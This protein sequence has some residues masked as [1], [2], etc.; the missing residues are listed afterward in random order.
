[1]TVKIMPDH[2]VS[3][4][5]EPTNFKKLKKTVISVF[6]NNEDIRNYALARLKKVQEEECKLIENIELYIKGN[7]FLKGGIIYR[8]RYISMNILN[9]GTFPSSGNNIA[10]K[11]LSDLFKVIKEKYHKI[12]TKLTQTEAEK[13]DRADNFLSKYHEKSTE[14]F[15]LEQKDLHASQAFKS[16]L[17][18]LKKFFKKSVNE[19]IYFMYAWPTDEKRSKEKWIQPFLES[20]Q[21][22]L[23]KAGFPDVRFDIVSNRM[24]ADINKFMEKTES[25]SYVLL[26]ASESLRIKHS[27]GTSAVCTEFN[28]VQ[29][30]R[31]KDYKEGLTRIFPIILSGSHETSLP[32][33]FKRFITVRDW[34][35]GGYLK[36]FQTLFIELLGLPPE[37]YRKQLNNLWENSA[38]KYPSDCGNLNFY[39]QK[40]E[41]LEE[42][43]VPK[44]VNRLMNISFQNSDDDTPKSVQ[45]LIKAKKDREKI[46]KFAKGEVFPLIKEMYKTNAMLSIFTFSKKG[47]WELKV[48]VDNLYVKIAMIDDQEKK[49]REA[50][51]RKTL[52]EY[53]DPRPTDHG[54]IFKKELDPA[55]IFSEELLEKGERPVVFGSAG[56]GKTTFVNHMLSLWSKGE[57]WTKFKI[58][59]CLPLRNLNKHF[60][61]K[62][63]GHVYKASELLQREYPN[64]GIDFQ[65]LLND[66]EFLKESLLIL[67]GYDGLPSEA[68]SK[69]RH[70]FKAFED[71]KKLFPNIL[72]T[73]RSAN[74]IEFNSTQEFEI[75]GF[76][77][78]QIETYISK[79][80]D[81]IGVEKAD[82]QQ[83]IESLKSY[84]SKTPLADSLAHIPINLSI[85][86]ALFNEDKTLFQKDKTL[87]TTKLY[88]YITN[89][90]YKVFLLRSGIGKDEVRSQKS[91]Q[92]HYLVAPLNKVLQ[93]IAI[94]AMEQDSLY[95]DQVKI[96]E[97]VYRNNLRIEQVKSIGLFR[98]EGGKGSFI[99]YTFQE[100]LTATFIAQLYIDGKQGKA[101]V[102]IKTHKF[103]PRYSLVLSM[104]AGYL[105]SQK[106][107]KSLQAF[108]D[109]LFSPPRDL[110]KSYELSL[111]AQCF[112]EC[113]FPEEIT[114]YKKEF[115][116]N[117]IH[118]IEEAPEKKIIIRLL[119][120]TNLLKNNEVLEKVRKVSEWKN[121]NHA[122][123]KLLAYSIKD[124][125]SEFLPILGQ[126]LSDLESY[127]IFRK[128]S[129]PIQK[130][131][132]EKLKNLADKNK[133]ETFL[134]RL[135]YHMDMRSSTLGFYREVKDPGINA[136]MFLMH[137]ARKGNKT[138][139]EFLVKSAWDYLDSKKKLDHKLGKDKINVLKEIV[140]LNRVDCKVFFK[141]LAG[142]ITSTSCLAQSSEKD[143]AEQQLPCWKLIDV[144]LDL[145]FQPELINYDFYLN[146]LIEVAKNKD[147]WISKR[148][149]DFLESIA[150]NRKTSAGKV[151]VVLENLIRDKSFLHVKK[152][153][154]LSLSNIMILQKEANMDSVALL[155]TAGE[156]FPNLKNEVVVRLSEI[157]AKISRIEKKI[158]D[159]LIT[160][161]TLNKQMHPLDREKITCNLLRR[162]IDKNQ[163]KTKIINTL[164]GIAFRYQISPYSSGV[165]AFCIEKLA[166]AGLIS[167][168]KQAALP[169]I[170]FISDTQ[171]I[172][173]Q[174]N[175][176]TGSS[177][178]SSQLK[179]V[180][181][182]FKLIKFGY[183]LPQKNLEEMLFSKSID[184]VVY[185]D[186]VCG[187]IEILEKKKDFFQKLELAII[188][189][190]KKPSD[191]YQMT[192]CIE[193]MAR[194]GY[195]KCS[196]N[197]KSL[198]NFLIKNKE[199][200]GIDPKIRLS[201]ALG[202]IAK[203]ESE[204]KAHATGVMLE[205]LK[206]KN[207]SIADYRR[208]NHL[209]K[210]LIDVD[211]TLPQQD[212]IRTWVSI[213]VFPYNAE[214]LFGASMLHYEAGAWTNK[215]VLKQVIAG[216]VEEAQKPE[217]QKDAVWFLS[218]MAK[219]DQDS[220]EQVRKS[221][222]EVALYNIEN[223]IDF[224]AFESLE[225]SWFTN[226]EEILQN[227]FEKAFSSKDKHFLLKKISQNSEEK[228]INCK[229][230]LSS[231]LSNEKN[232]CEISV[233]LDAG[234]ML[235]KHSPYNQESILEKLLEITNKQGTN[236]LLSIIR[237][238]IFYTSNLKNQANF[239][240]KNILPLL[241]QIIQCNKNQEIALLCRT[242]DSASSAL[243]L[244]SESED[245]ISIFLHLLLE[246][247]NKNAGKEVTSA[248]IRLAH[249]SKDSGQKII[250][251]V[252][253]RLIELKSMDYSNVLRF[254]SFI[255]NKLEQ[256]E[257]VSKENL[258]ILVSLMNPKYSFGRA[259]QGIL[260]VLQKVKVE[261]LKN[262]IQDDGSFVLVQ[263]ICYLTGKP[264]VYD[265]YKVNQSLLKP[266]NPEQA[267][268]EVSWPSSYIPL[269]HDNG[270]QTQGMKNSKGRVMASSSPIKKQ[271]ILIRKK[272]HIS[273]NRTFKPYLRTK[274]IKVPF[275]SDSDDKLFNSPSQ[276]GGLMEDDLR[277]GT[278]R[279]RSLG[280]NELKYSN[281]R[282]KTMTEDNPHLEGKTS[283]ELQ[284]TANSS[285]RTRNIGSMID[286]T[287]VD[288]FD[289]T[290]TT[291]LYPSRQKLSFPLSFFLSQE[292]TSLS[293]GKRGSKPDDFLHI[294]F[295]THAGL[296][297]YGSVCYANASLQALTSKRFINQ[298]ELIQQNYKNLSS[299]S[300]AYLQTLREIF[301]KS[302]SQRQF[303]EFLVSE[304]GNMST[305]LEN[306]ESDQETKKEAAAQTINNILTRFEGA[307]SGKNSLKSRAQGFLRKIDQGNCTEN[308]YLA[309]TVK[310]R[311]LCLKVMQSL[312]NDGKTI[313]AKELYN[314][315]GFGAPFQDIGEFTTRFLDQI[316]FGKII[317]H[318]VLSISQSHKTK[319]ISK[320][321]DSIL[322]LPLHNGSIQ[323][324]LDK[325]FSTEE[326]EILTEEG[327]THSKVVL[328]RAPDILPLTLKRFTDHARTIKVTID[329]EIYVMLSNGKKFWYTLQSMGCYQPGHYV[330]G[331]RYET[332][333]GTVQWIE[334]NDAS[335]PKVIG[336]QIQ[337]W[338][339]EP[340]KNACLL[341]YHKKN[342]T[343]IAKLATSKPSVSNSSSIL[344]NASP[345]KTHSNLSSVHDFTSE[346]TAIENKQKPTSV[347]EL[348]KLENAIKAS[349][350]SD[351]QKDSLIARI[352]KIQSGM[353]SSSSSNK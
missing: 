31:E 104:I 5:L 268:K 317:F 142:K 94:Y 67:E 190:L 23:K 58:V 90:F 144:L 313:S 47:E 159:F 122:L 247:F 71:L 133:F 263:K 333:D 136:F 284:P 101:K 237:T 54:T 303:H 240:K 66:S 261:Y 146:T 279:S 168:F 225:A 115:I 226:I 118:Y 68:K 79:F 264:L 321:R 289:P 283:K 2:E 227:I 224:S 56:I 163:D 81:E 87:T 294:S 86:C 193:K 323:E 346:L 108:F 120:R 214:K 301:E 314:A 28:H 14:L 124:I 9:K 187:F 339:R 75:V 342:E 134:G 46:Y 175:K 232:T 266:I 20:L 234:I 33:G 192:F 336:P 82:K 32:T 165:A 139:Q 105:A 292:G 98:V 291:Q 309:D 73:S 252:F 117:V 290:T 285:G 258:E 160:A 48:P 21:K 191:T 111:F 181:A 337:S 166:S 107:Q 206:I 116:P 287:Q 16:Y 44:D 137:F 34:R 135:A 149:I 204:L 151:K 257:E 233:R 251:L 345:L 25:S 276:G 351:R 180:E 273:L 331:C 22:A 305:A 37:K 4:R 91:P 207:L 156:Q 293:T 78:S 316:G 329:E 243:R 212:T 152:Q 205:L 167:D 43:V 97:I 259:Y 203:G 308:A 320:E 202:E 265:G 45:R 88:S 211:C 275:I 158:T 18:A 154:I 334:H 325:F 140:N 244:I 221:F 3:F 241:I 177:K 280:T 330:T 306:L 42:C 326:L 173:Y 69:G 302:G 269:T 281:K 295:N 246:M 271:K 59:F 249:I 89:H 198:L 27:R 297:N 1:M 84:L 344:N 255:D 349:N 223:K 10:L 95:V 141:K 99:H 40:R 322:Q 8:I 310:N 286:Q 176:L 157:A 145:F 153:S 74:T 195:F 350:L 19:T 169:L 77:D 270:Q 347:Y 26:F 127:H 208:L 209:I 250:E 231:I 6:G 76:G 36:H 15:Q 307:F 162:I 61:P 335:Y 228:I 315:I 220:F 103:I 267:F 83:K 188:D 282:Q 256:G 216:L 222:W 51:H 174:E 341:V 85:L 128:S 17:K 121:D 236:E 129:I 184:T 155:L 343:D 296:T 49:E 218:H 53:R 63:P 260:R 194:H 348:Q 92:Q 50:S 170:Y 248:L 161:I 150:R 132:I 200:I 112:K 238:L 171:P 126:Q 24:G 324:V 100:F 93:E 138:A 130:E 235:L 262:L 131:T 13:R 353:S 217:K 72:V 62:I 253:K 102:I 338:D 109:D 278:K 210:E 196:K 215:K 114:Q 213:N 12:K 288:G 239:L 80:F 178:S 277:R 274:L 179:A 55:E 106:K 41:E 319:T 64:L 96:E 65:H 304:Y 245:Y 352:K 298:L 229:D 125:P 29:N 186:L 328:D 60:Y 11:I 148:A 183:S 299:E 164:V 57:C 39:D 119:E 172:N 254:A 35:S 201:L 199:S 242:I 272:P 143:E 182:L 113:A 340:E 110:A 311:L 197:W 327:Y 332:G 189:R 230:I 70:L 7:R 123:L 30:K 318:K 219:P 300:F 185:R 147:Y 312:L 52:S 38:S